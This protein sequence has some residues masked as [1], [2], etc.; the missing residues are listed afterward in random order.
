MD[1]KIM[2]ESKKRDNMEI[3]KFFLHKSTN[4]LVKKD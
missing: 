1:D 3:H 4:V 2:I